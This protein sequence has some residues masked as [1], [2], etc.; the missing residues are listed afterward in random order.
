MGYIRCYGVDAGSGVPFVAIITDEQNPQDYVVA[1]EKSMRS[2]VDSRWKRFTTDYSKPEDT[3]TL[4][5]TLSGSYTR[6]TPWEPVDNPVEAFGES[7]RIITAR[8][9][10]MPPL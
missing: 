5:T 3:T 8:T 1:G 2:M 10:I 6:V 4:A 9:P 7:Q